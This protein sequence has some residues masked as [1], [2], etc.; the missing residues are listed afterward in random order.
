MT[1]VIL[2]ELLSARKKITLLVCFSVGH[3]ELYHNAIMGYG[4]KRKWLRKITRFHIAFPAF[5]HKVR[6]RAPQT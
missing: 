5:I 2:S 4:R 6:V 1:L 3:F